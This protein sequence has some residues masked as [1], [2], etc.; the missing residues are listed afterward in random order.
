MLF[1]NN[2][3][4]NNDNNNNNNNNNNNKHNCTGLPHQFFRKNCYQCRS[5]KNLKIKNRKKF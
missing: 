1:N 5:C 2:N 3:N 4:D